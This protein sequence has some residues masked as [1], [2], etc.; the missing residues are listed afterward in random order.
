MA[1]MVGE[2]AAKLIIDDKEYNVRLKEARKEG[3]TWATD[4]GKSWTNAGK[5]LDKVGQ[6]LTKGVTL[7]IV[8]AGTAIIMTASNFESSMNRVKG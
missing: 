5:G 6:S 4:M 7:P 8:G 1:F 3:E 2:L